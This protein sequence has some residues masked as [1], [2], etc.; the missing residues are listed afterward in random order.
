MISLDRS[1]FKKIK[2]LYDNVRIEQSA[3]DIRNAFMGED[4]EFSVFTT[5]SALDTMVILFDDKDN[6]ATRYIS[7]A[8]EAD[9]NYLVL[10]ANETVEEMRFNAACMLGKIARKIEKT[11]KTLSPI[12]TTKSKGFSREDKHFACALLMPK[13]ELLSFITSKDE[14]GNYLYLDE[15]NQISFRNINAVADHFGVPF[16][17]CASRIFHVFEEMRKTGKKPVYYVEGCYEKEEYKKKRENYKAKDRERDMMEVVP[18]HQQNRAILISHLIDSLHYRSWGRLSEIAKQ[19]LL[20][21]LVKSDSVNEGVVKNEEEAKA[22]INN[23]I[24]S[25]G[26]IYDGRLITKD[27]EYNLS[28]EQLVVLGEYE[29]YNKTLERGLIK[30]IAKSNPRLE[31]LTKLDYKEAINCLK[32]R[33]LTT[34]IC[35]L[36]RR[37]F[38]NLSAKY[39][40]ERG[41]MYRSAPVSLAGTNVRTIDPYFIPQEMDNIS[42][43]ILEILKK[44]ANGELSNSEYIAQVNEC[45]YDMIRMQPFSDGNKRTSRLL[46]NILYQEKG[47]PYVLIPV[48]EWGNYVSAWSNNDVSEYNEM[49]HRMILD[50][51]SYFYGG[52][53][54]TDITHSR[55]FGEK[56]I[57]ANRK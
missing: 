8:K 30:G 39:G 23:Y 54:V 19:R 4:G 18:N 16:N 46:S 31:Y 15:N 20:V 17:Q 41:G 37:L 57:M 45:I 52:Q 10:S 44:N 7:F 47:I 48:K 12:I 56:I 34:Y 25:N 38:S 43:R 26:T 24:A 51:Y 22:I 27:G 50:S 1:G 9:K 6:P 2:A 29:L 13:H 14:N 21:N 33:D 55:V 32:E 5:I 40:E 49:M 53:S 11:S 35:D 42:W 36:H 3:E 28:D